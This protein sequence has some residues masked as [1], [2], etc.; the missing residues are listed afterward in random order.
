MQIELKT[1]PF[2]GHK[3]CKSIRSIAHFVG[4]IYQRRMC[5]RMV[6]F[7]RS[8]WLVLARSAVTGDG[9]AYRSML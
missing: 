3:P 7:C 5:M 9:R 4:S 2:Q 6:Q 1:Q 8:T